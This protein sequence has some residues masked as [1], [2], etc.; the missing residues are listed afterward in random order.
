MTLTRNEVFANGR[1]SDAHDGIDVNGVGGIVRCNLSRENRTLGDIPNGGGG[2]GIEVGSKTPGVFD[3]NVI[4]YNTAR[5]NVSAG[6]SIRAGP[7]A[8]FI[9]KNV[10]WENQVGISVNAEMRTTRRHL[11]SRNSTFMN[12][13]LG[14]DLSSFSV[15]ILV[16]SLNTGAYAAEVFRAGIQ[17]IERGQMEAARSLG[18]TYMQAMRYA[19]VPQAV[20]RVIPPLMNEFVILIKDTSLILVLGLAITELDIYNFARQG[21]SDSFNSTYFVA[22]AAGYLAVTLPLIGLVNAVERR[23]HSGL[24]VATG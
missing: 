23:L 11:L 15:A 24:V 3:N 6:I 13:G 4:E 8:D 7:V 17:S 18:M 20:R 21:F 22:A 19:I 9:E 2:N 16:F 5:G 10:V 12:L 14:I 1:L